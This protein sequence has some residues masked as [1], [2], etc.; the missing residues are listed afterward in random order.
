MRSLVTFGS[1]HNG[2]AEFQVC[3]TWDLVCRGAMAGVRGNAYTAWVQGNVVPAQYYREVNAST[4]LASKAYLDGS[5]FLADV[6]NE[7]KVKNEVYKQRLS[8]LERFVMYVFEKD[9]T[10]LPK[11]SGWFAEVNA[12][13]GE[14][15][16]LQKRKMYE[17]D[18]LGL[19][20]LDERGSLV[21]RNATGA[22]MRLTEK[23]LEESFRDFFGPER[24][25][26][27]VLSKVT[28]EPQYEQHQHQQHVISSS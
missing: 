17:E 5:S 19:K 2:I 14:V 27:D 22:H 18:W 11:E 3:G 28:L 1:Q 21:F 23:V 20:V 25:S 10:V 9:T 26:W 6:N 4:G 16:P 24:E 15:T 13:S 12:T 8:R 7:R